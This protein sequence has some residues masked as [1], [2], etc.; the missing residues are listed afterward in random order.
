MRTADKLFGALSLCKKAGKL[1][2]GFDAVCD[3]M[4]AGEA[5]LLLFASD[6]SEKTQKRAVEQNSGGIP[7]KSLPYMQQQ[8]A[9]LTNKPVGVLAVADVD[10]AALCMGAFA[11]PAGQ[12]HKE[13]PV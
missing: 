8:I 1:V 6:V 5:K 9:I 11:A 7:V 2:C 13:E 4:L 10:L 12:P 3:S